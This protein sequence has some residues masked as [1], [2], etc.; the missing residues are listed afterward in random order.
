MKRAPPVESA[1]PT[2]SF[3]RAADWRE[4]LE[5]KH[6]LA[7]GVWL[8]LSK[9]GCNTESVTYSEALDVALCFGW[10]DG[11]KMPLDTHYWL[12]KFC[13]RGP[14]SKWSKINRDKAQR[15]IA[16]GLIHQAGHD[17][18]LAAQR[19][20][21]WQSAY[22]GQASAKIP[23]DLRVALDANAAA[24]AFFE[25]LDSRNRYAMVYRI[26]TA[27]KAETRTRN[28]AKFIQMLEKGEKIHP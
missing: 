17:A 27:K 5:Q 25:A 15:L 26:Q 11:K 14:R 3:A 22:E 23:E 18:I 12:Q 7:P 28:V 4:W 8:K 24:K 16:D 2:E 6:A 10:I 19:D 1:L 9:K 21:R 13:P 20:G